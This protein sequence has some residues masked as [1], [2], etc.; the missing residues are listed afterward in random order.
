VIENLI[1]ILEQ[2]NKTGTTILI[3]EQDV[4][5]ALEQATRGYVLETGHITFSDTAQA[6]LKDERV[7]KAY[8]GI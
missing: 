3:V 4:Q 7:K 8:L 6:L 5:T 2:V 1:A